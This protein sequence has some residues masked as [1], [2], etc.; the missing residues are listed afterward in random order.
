MIETELETQLKSVQAD[1]DQ[2]TE[3]Y[4]TA[5]VSKLIFLEDLSLFWLA[6]KL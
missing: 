6:E 2:M 1:L 5:K 3:K 4:E